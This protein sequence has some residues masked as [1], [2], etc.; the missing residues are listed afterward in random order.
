MDVGLFHE[1]LPNPQGCIA[2]MSEEDVPEFPVLRLANIHGTLI[3]GIPTRGFLSDRDEG[4]VQSQIPGEVGTV[5]LGARFV[6]VMK[7]GN[8]V[9]EDGIRQRGQAVHCPLTPELRELLLPGM[10]P[11]RRR[12]GRRL[13]TTQA[14]QMNMEHG[15][16]RAHVVR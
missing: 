15:L 14:R 1:V 10:R 12:R 16:I 6:R 8:L 5:P 7:L 4:F 9:Q 2:S 11:R 13:A 3:A